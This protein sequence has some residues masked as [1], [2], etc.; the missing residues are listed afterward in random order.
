MFLTEGANHCVSG[1]VCLVAEGEALSVVTTHDGA[2][3]ITQGVVPLLVYDLW[4]HACHPDHKNERAAFLAAWR[5]QLA[6]WRFAGHQYAAATGSVR[7][8]AI[9]N[10]SNRL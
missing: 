1:W 6:C 7:P 4:E 2:S 8:G 10:L 3:P 5:G 9:R